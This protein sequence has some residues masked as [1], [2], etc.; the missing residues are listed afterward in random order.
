[1]TSVF[2]LYI[3][4]S[5]LLF[6]GGKLVT[7]IQKYIN[8]KLGHYKHLVLR[9]ITTSKTKKKG[10]IN[11]K[12]CVNNNFVHFKKIFSQDTHKVKFSCIFV[13]ST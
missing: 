5:D 6:K 8:F 9:R 11:F 10:V 12:M 2:L 13:F 4:L 1:M 7:C 3:I